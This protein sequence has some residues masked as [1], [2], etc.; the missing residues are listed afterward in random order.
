MKEHKCA[1]IDCER[2]TRRNRRYIVTHSG[3]SIYFCGLKCLAEHYH[4]EAMS[5]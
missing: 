2:I 1:H 5:L 3:S 4:Y